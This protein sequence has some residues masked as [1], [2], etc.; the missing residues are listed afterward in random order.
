MHYPV[1]MSSSGKLPF[2]IDSSDE[3]SSWR[4]ETF[5][6]KEPETLEWL[7]TYV[8]N[9]EIPVL[10]DVGANIG[11]YS[12]YYLSLKPQTETISCEPFQENF[13]LLIKNLDLNGFAER[14]ILV[15]NPLA[16][17]SEEGFAEI[18]D[19]R[20]GG[21]GYRYIR[22]LEA[23]L[24]LIKIKT[25]SIDEILRHEIRQVIIKIDTDGND[26]EI[27][28]GARESLAS[29]KVISVLIE[30]DV[31][32]QKRISNFLDQFGL[33][34][35]LELDN[36]PNHSDLRRINAGTKERNRIYTKNF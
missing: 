6:S 13:H 10:L 31:D 22:N 28:Q 8:S 20:P 21:S 33:V 32:G 30:S 17:V 9:D 14:A 16:R 24:D 25:V 18:N 27:L 19:S 34:P 1:I 11:L 15:Q 5:F 4:A 36:L 3:L 23:E 29:G 26:F 2:E 12:L 35:D 7:R